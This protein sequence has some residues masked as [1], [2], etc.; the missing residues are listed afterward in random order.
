MTF[1][2]T[3]CPA[4]TVPGALVYSP[5][6]ILYWPLVMLIGTAISTPATVTVAVL[7]LAGTAPVTA[8]KLNASGVTSAAVVALKVPFAPP[9]V[10]VAT[11]AVLVLVEVVT[12]TAT[13][14]PELIVPEAAV[15]AAP[16]IE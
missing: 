4:L 15:N 2:V 8:V 9:T 5:V 12:L 16:S 1:T 13:L 6:P 3:T 10:R 11:T 14:W 7:T